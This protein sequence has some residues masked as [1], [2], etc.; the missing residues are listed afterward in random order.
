MSEPLIRACVIGSPIAHSRSPLIHRYWLKKHGISGR[1]DKIEVTPSELE[2]FF[3]RIRSGE[4][5]GCNITIPLKEL[6]FQAVGRTDALTARLKSVNT[7]YVDGGQLV[8]TSTDGIGFMANLRQTITDWQ[9]DGQAVTMLGAGGAARALTATLIDAGVARIVIAN[10][11]MSRAEAIAAEHDARVSTCD[12]SDLPDSLADTD[13][14]VNSTSLGMERQPPLELSLETLRPNAVVADIVYAPLETDLL[15][16]A[17]RRGHRCVDGLGML[18]HQA[19]P[20]FEKWFGI[21]PEVTAELRDIIAAD[22][23]DG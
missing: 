5:A 11:T 8:G 12:W 7:V 1:Y 13:L 2:V 22:I 18:L 21:R 10:R 4:I 16:Q 3:D 15:K 17:A 6:A 14:L 20:G 19:V 23:E 9:T